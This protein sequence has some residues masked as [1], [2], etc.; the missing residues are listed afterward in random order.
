MVPILIRNFGANNKICA[1]TDS[2]G[3]DWRQEL[4]WRLMPAGTCPA[5]AKTKYNVQTKHFRTYLATSIISAPTLTIC[6]SGLPELVATGASYQI[7]TN[8]SFI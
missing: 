8:T 1:K 4:I 3:A 5:D 6:C 7:G 2:C